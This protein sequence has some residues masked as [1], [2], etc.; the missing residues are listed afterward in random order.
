MS[1]GSLVGWTEKKIKELKSVKSSSKW[2]PDWLSGASSAAGWGPF[3]FELCL[4]QRLPGS[5][6]GRSLE[7]FYISPKQGVGTLVVNW[8]WG[9]K[10]LLNNPKDL[11]SD[12]SG[13]VK[14]WNSSTFTCL[15]E[16]AALGGRDK[17]IPGPYR[18]AWLVKTRDF[19]IQ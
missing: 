4:S 17:Q 19:L 12:S 16:A 2:P 8:G 11:G 6:G 1:R 14:S 10:E 3:S 9:P 15:P 18:P 5:K 7:S 13:H